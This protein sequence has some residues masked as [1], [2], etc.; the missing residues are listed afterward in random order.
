M[1]VDFDDDLPIV[2]AHHHLWDLDGPIDY[3]WLRHPEHNW[4]GDYSA[5]CR[6]YLPPE[7]RQDTALHNVIATVHVEAECNRAQQTEETAW[8]MEQNAIHGMP[9]V[10]VGHAWVDTPNAEAVLAKQAA[11]PLMRGIRTKPITGATARERDSVRG[12]P[13]SLQD[14]VWRNGLKLLQKYRLSWDLRVPWYHLE[15]ATEVCR[16]L[17][18]LAIVLNHSGYPSDRDPESLAGWRRGM[19]AIAACPNVHVKLSGLCVAGQPWTLAA[20]KALILFMVEIF[21]ADRC[22]FA[23]NYPVDGLK[24]S[25][26]Y[27]CTQY[28]QAL[29]GL[30]AED[31]AKIFAGNALRFY[32]I[33]LPSE[34]GSDS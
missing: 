24:G 12:Q 33:D 26:D 13:R 19:L 9:N 29:S 22:M 34:S 31:R 15:E 6:T 18:D 27:L 17:P 3:Q 11:C 5:F 32:R 1:R 25:W 4:L 14:P 7:Y 2:D 16:E 28:K 21:G 30:R 23:S 20:N 8:L 10:L